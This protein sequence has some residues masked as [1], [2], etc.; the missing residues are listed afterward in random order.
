MGSL[1]AKVHD[2]DHGTG[3]WSHGGSIPGVATVRSMQLLG[4]LSKALII[5]LHYFT[6]HYITCH[7]ADAFIP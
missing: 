3:T 4:P 2:W 5:T 1:V 7:L 6:L